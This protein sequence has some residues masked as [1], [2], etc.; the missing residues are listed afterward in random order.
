MIG[1]DEKHMCRKVATALDEIGVRYIREGHVEHFRPDFLIEELKFVI[2]VDGSC[3]KLPRQKAV[4]AIK[5]Q[6]YKC[7]GYTYLRL[8]QANIERADTLRKSIRTKI[9]QIT[10]E[11]YWG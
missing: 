7:R 10:D 6:F 1:V 3:H 5:N 8:T 2:E 4:D 9:C 11:P